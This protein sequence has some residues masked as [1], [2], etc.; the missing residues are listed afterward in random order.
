MTVHWVFDDRERF[1]T[2]TSCPDTV[3]S[4]RSHLVRG[5]FP[6]GNIFHYFMHNWWNRTDHDWRHSDVASRPDRYAYN[7]GTWNDHT[8][9]GGID[10]N[11]HGFRNFLEYVHPDVMEDARAGRA[12]LVVDNLNEGFYD[13][14]FYEFMHSSLARYGVPPA[15]LAWL[16]GNVL[17]GRG[18]AA[19]CDANGTRQRMHVIGFN[20]L[21]YMQQLN[22]RH[23]GGP[24]PTWDDHVARKLVPR[25]VKT[26]NCL[27]RV[28]RLHR[29][30]LMMLLIDLGL[31][32]KGLISHD[33]IKYHAWPEHGISQ[34][35]VDRAN[36]MLPM[37][38]DDHDFGNN[39]AMHINTDIYLN[40]WVSLVT[41]THAVDQDHN[42]FIS[43][44]VWKPIWA[45]QP[46]MVLGQRGMLSTMRGMGY[47][48][49]P[50]LFD[51]GYDSMPFMDRVRSILANVQSADVVYDKM[52]WVSQ[53]R[54]A[55]EHNRRVFM[56][57]DWYNDRSHHEFM[58]AYNGDRR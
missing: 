36:G 2:M 4:D 9:W 15:S 41:E 18:Y 24:E 32:T 27:N 38:V 13:E 10:G 51:E 28:D 53:A 33:R 45:L 17:D 47:A 57:A 25:R 29:E 34:E 48:T 1:L 16:T 37:V 14:G 12:L 58:A 50:E 42:M 54:E 22:L 35:L 56:S 46:F 7:I 30:L 5:R 44:K 8:Y 23:S 11:P 49:F 55:C 39:K 19:W 40:S 52:G 26:F 3:V 20:H 21:M 31:H 6:I 43:E